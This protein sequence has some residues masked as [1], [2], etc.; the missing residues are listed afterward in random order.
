MP[1]Q[2]DDDI[3]RIIAKIPNMSKNQFISNLIMI[4]LDDVKLLDR[5][6]IFTAIEYTRK[7]MANAAELFLN[8][9]ISESE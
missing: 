5:V 2:S 7:L 8:G 1:K 4:G 9:T 6:G 3:R